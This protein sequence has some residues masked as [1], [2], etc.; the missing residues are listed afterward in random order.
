M[1]ELSKKCEKCGAIWIHWV[2]VSAVH[3]AAFGGNDDVIL[4]QEMECECCGHRFMAAGIY[5]LKACVVVKDKEQF[6]RHWHQEM[7]WE[8]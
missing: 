2:P 5:D 4:L 7:G 8:E 3:A 1:E 6:R